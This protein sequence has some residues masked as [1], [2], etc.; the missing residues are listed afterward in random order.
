RRAHRMTTE[1]PPPNARTTLPDALQVFCRGGR[2]SIVAVTARAGPERFAL[3]TA[4][5]RTMSSPGVVVATSEGAGAYREFFAGNPT[6]PQAW[7][8]LEGGN[9]EGGI[10]AVARALARARELVA[11]P[12][13]EESLSALWLPAHILEAFGLLPADRPGLVV[14]DSWDGLLSEYLP[15]GPAPT[16]SWPSAEE[17]ESILIR[18]LRQYAQAL[19]VVIVDASSR[20]RIGELADGVVEV[21]SRGQYGTLTGSMLILRRVGEGRERASLRFHLDGGI[22]RWQAG[23]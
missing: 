13:R 7:T 10:R 5:L 14:I 12:Q 23:R 4:I 1:D 11:D 21:V 6:V 2:A 3:T 15:G 16:E 9:P 20:S 8:V 22:I 19:V 18:T 17:L